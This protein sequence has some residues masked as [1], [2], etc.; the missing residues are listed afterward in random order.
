MARVILDESG[1]PATFWGE[2]AFTV[3]TILNK[4]NVQVNS[5]QIPYELWYSK[6]P[7]VKKFRD[8]GRKCFIKRI[9]EKLGKFEPR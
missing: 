8:F 1:T 4:E 6:S 3:M 2:A 5:D 9:D 7:I